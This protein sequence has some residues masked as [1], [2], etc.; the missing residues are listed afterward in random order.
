MVLG[1]WL[2]GVIVL[3]LVVLFDEMVV[4]VLFDICIVVVDVDVVLYSCSLDLLWD[5]L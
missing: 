4:E 1:G 5:L 2:I 3:S